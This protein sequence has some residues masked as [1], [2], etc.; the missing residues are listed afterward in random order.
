MKSVFKPAIALL[1][2]LTYPKKL[3]ALGLFLLVPISVTMYLLIT[4]L[5]T[6]INFARKE[7]EGI[8]YLVQLRKFSEAV[9]SHRS[10]ATAYVTGDG[11]LKNQLG[12]LE[13]R[14]DKSA[15][16]LDTVDRRLDADLKTGDQWKS[17][18]SHWQELKESY[19]GMSPQ[20][21]FD[22][23]TAIIAEATALVGHVGDTSN[24]IL[25]PALDSYYLMD[26]IIN[27]LP[28]LTDST[29]QAQTLAL[30]KEPGKAAGQGEKNKL[31]FL[32]VQIKST[33]DALNTGMQVAFNNNNSLRPGLEPGT[34]EYIEDTDNFINLLNTQIL[35]PAEFSP[36]AY[37]S[38]GA[39][40]VASAYRL[41]DGAAPALD[42]L[43]GG[44]ISSYTAKKNIAI[45]VTM[46]GVLVAFYLFIGFSLSV[47]EII[48]S[49]RESAVR[50]ASGD[51][52]ARVS[53]SSRDEMHT[54]AQSFN[55]AA[56]SFGLMIADIIEAA[57]RL[58]KS[59]DS[60]LDISGS[61][62]RY[63]SEMDEMNKKAQLV[64]SNVEHITDNIYQA[65]QA[66][67]SVSSN[68]SSIS[69]AVEGL[70]QTVNNLASSSEQVSAG[71]EQ[72][73]NM[74]N[75]TSNTVQTI[76]RS[77]REVSFSVNS[78]AA[79]VKE[80]N[81][82]LNEVSR[83]CE[84]S[85]EITDNAETRAREAK[86]MIQRLNESSRQIG[87]I[88][89]VIN[90]IAEQTKM[91][92]LNAAIEAAGAGEAGKGFNV[93]ASEVKDLARQTAEATEEIRQQIEDMQAVMGK[94]VMS[95]QNIT[96]VIT[97]I[98]GITS[99]IAS[100]VTEQSATTGEIST[101]M[102][103]AA[104]GVSLISREIT[105]LADNTENMALIVNQSS[106]GVG[107]I[108][109]SASGISGTAEDLAQNTETA[110]TRM[111]QMAENASRISQRASEIYEH[112]REISRVSV[113][114]SS[115]AEE[116]GRAARDLAELAK[117]MEVLVRRFKL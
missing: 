111:A 100:A 12:E 17:I 92:A 5:N 97:E 31:V 35:N 21:C 47:V 105:E 60:L 42:S 39:K 73:S 24:L 84:R 102:I 7:R 71:S 66:T 53:C 90:D 29:T 3:A 65:A 104:E 61:M 115:G 88:V 26:A 72:V 11:T 57:T 93:V 43:L 52:T 70:S 15:G 25:D 75:E 58:N 48:R 36:D 50:L 85:T 110:S 40:A 44:R 82:S 108:A 9:Q 91:L 27:K 23:H 30:L 56:G 4:E 83:N 107:E 89:E 34:K 98:A 79:A 62:A 8:E 18:R 74:V 10:A 112:I 117:T 1:N 63:R 94:S 54:V 96:G 116:T 46:A 101:S 113:N 64:S 38:G 106:Q 51:L 20:E 77:A 80:I 76:S 55:Q 19:A 103:A 87:K 32:S 114:S 95:V 109:V 22:R 33:A 99:N 69:G 68:I 14:A 45:A 86:E 16:E 81:L 78:V 37:S 41:Y 59:S 49:L 2:R 13:A 28:A 6:G 67:A